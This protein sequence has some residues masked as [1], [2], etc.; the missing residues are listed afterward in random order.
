MTECNHITPKLND[1]KKIGLMALCL[2]FLASTSIVRAQDPETGLYRSFFGEES[3]SW[4]GVTEYYDTP[5]ENH[6]LRLAHDTVFA[7]RTYKKVE[8]SAIYWH[9]GY[10]ERRDPS[11][12]FYLYE[13]RT[14]G[15]LWCR[16]QNNDSV[17]LI[18]DMSLSIGD[19]VLLPSIIRWFQGD[20]Y[21]VRD[22]T[23]QD[24]LFTIILKSKYNNYKTIKYVEGIG[25]TNLFDYLCLPIIGSQLVCCQRD[26]E[27]AYHCPVEGWPEEDCIVH[28][29]D[30]NEIEQDERI[31]VWPNPC[32]DWFIIK[33]DHTLVAELYD[34]MGH[35][36]IEN[37]VPYKKIDTGHLPRGVYL[38]RVKLNGSIITKK[39]VIK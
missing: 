15:R 12:D 25:C 14:S 4:N 20:K 30:I 34:V 27:L 29:V 2:V 11:L 23:T 8:Y 38:L 26:G 1:M 36:I 31:S 13:D 16:H 5:W 17:F 9:N 6:I 3:S 7:S 35:R 24:G 10:F 33:G 21:V 19:T 22:T 37:I 32:E 39:I 18:A 28:A